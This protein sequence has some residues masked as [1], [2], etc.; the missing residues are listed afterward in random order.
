LEGG[1]GKK[2]KGE[3]RNAKEKTLKI[4]T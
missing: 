1:K 3:E 2:A 4:A